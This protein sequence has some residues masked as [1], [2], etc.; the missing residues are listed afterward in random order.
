MVLLA[1]G[2][3][4]RGYCSILARQKHGLTNEFCCVSL[5]FSA[6]YPGSK[7]VLF[8]YHSYVC[9]PCCRLQLPVRETKQQPAQHQAPHSF[10]VQL[11]RRPNSLRQMAALPKARTSHQSR[12]WRQQER[13]RRRAERLRLGQV[14]P[15]GSLKQPQA[16]HRLVSFAAN[17][18]A[19]G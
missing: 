16:L 14:Q 6:C 15:R 17:V 3:G 9:W 13:L 12:V 7:T 1:V 18:H 19:P 2:Q 10:P 11:R 5:H 4:G 8:M